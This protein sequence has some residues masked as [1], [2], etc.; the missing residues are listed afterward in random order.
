VEDLITPEQFKVLVA[1]FEVFIP[2][3]MPGVCLSDVK[4]EEL[5]A[6]LLRRAK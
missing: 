2:V 4:S 1:G 3:G 5:L 6:E